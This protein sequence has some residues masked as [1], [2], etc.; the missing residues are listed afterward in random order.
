MPIT[1]QTKPLR[2]QIKRVRHKLRRVFADLSVKAGIVESIHAL[3]EN[4]GVRG[5]IIETRRNPQRA[6][7]ITIGPRRTNFV[8]L[9]IHVSAVQRTCDLQAL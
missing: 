3:L 4:L 1:L 8:R 2:Q 7:A 9:A 6:D 5:A